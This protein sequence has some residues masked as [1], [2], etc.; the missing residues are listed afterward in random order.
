MIDERRL[1]DAGFEIVTQ[2]L[3]ELQFASR[4]M[5]P[6]HDFVVR[7]DGHFQC[8]HATCAAGRR[9]HGEQAEHQRTPRRLVGPGRHRRQ[10]VDVAARFQSAVE[11]RAEQ[12]DRV[13]RRA[14]MPLDG[15]ACG[16]DLRRDFVGNGFSHDAR[17]SRCVRNRRNRRGER[18][19]L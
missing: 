14:E 17:V 18:E 7:D 12:V 8:A 9:R 10:Q 19:P 4:R 16:G 2:P 5:T 3:A 15:V 1:D 13:Q 6:R 11:R